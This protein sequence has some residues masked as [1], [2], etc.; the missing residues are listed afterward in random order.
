MMVAYRPSF[1][2]QNIRLE[3]G[4]KLGMHLNGHPTP[5]A[6]I[7]S[8]RLTSSYVLAVNE[9]KKQVKEQAPRRT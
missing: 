1:T 6:L 7:F 3:P 4:D 2:T 9:G 8:S 5:C